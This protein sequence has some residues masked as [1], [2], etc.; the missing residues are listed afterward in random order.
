ML[1]L[2]GAWCSGVIAGRRQV[3]LERRARCCVTHFPNPRQTLHIQPHISRISAFAA[4]IPAQ[5]AI[6]AALYA[7][8]LPFP[9]RQNDDYQTLKDYHGAAAG[10]GPCA[11]QGCALVTG[12]DPLGAARSVTLSPYV[13][14]LYVHPWH[15][16]VVVGTVAMT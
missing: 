10:L 12:P 15:A 16:P 8:R 2:V 3:P 5:M 11:A 13:L 14:T 9:G 6:G 1:V 4:E 7:L